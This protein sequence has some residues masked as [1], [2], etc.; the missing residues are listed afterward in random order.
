MCYSGSEVFSQAESGSGVI[1][2]EGLRCA[3]DEDSLLDCPSDVELGLSLCD[4][5]D[6]A[7]IRCYGNIM[8]IMPAL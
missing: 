7:G 3:G 6:D 8:M 5:S 4:H 2:L 1:Y